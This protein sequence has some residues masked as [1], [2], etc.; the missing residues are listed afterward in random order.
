MTSEVIQRVREELEAIGD[1][2][3]RQ[4]RAVE[5]YRSHGATAFAACRGVYR[6]DDRLF[7]L[8]D[9]PADCPWQLATRDPKEVIDKVFASVAAEVPAFVRAMKEA[10]VIVVGHLTA[11]GRWTL[12]YCLERTRP[13]AMCNVDPD[14]SNRVEYLMGGAPNAT[15]RLALKA[16][17]AGWSAVPEHLSR[18]SAIHDGFGASLK[19]WGVDTIL[20]V[21]RIEP[22]NAA[23]PEWLDLYCNSV[24]DRAV[25]PR[26]T[27]EKSLVLEWDLETGELGAPV[28]FFEWINIMWA[29]RVVDLDPYNFPDGLY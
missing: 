7:D 26:K 8:D 25:L 16:L 15:P 14:G 29:L 23:T 6:P 27:A 17:A 21:N 22:L 19:D 10:C 20:P 13:E 9:V 12:E 24:G 11:E 18:W 2:W 1:W 5:L 28:S 4:L 3:A